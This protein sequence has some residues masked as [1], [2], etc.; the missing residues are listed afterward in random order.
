[1]EKELVAEGGRMREKKDERMLNHIVWLC[2]GR[3]RH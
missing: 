3:E 1:M 2:D